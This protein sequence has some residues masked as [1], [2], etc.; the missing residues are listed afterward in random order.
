[1]YINSY[2]VSIYYSWIFN[3]EQVN[4]VNLLYTSAVDEFNDE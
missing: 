1:M 3:F 2:I 4:Y